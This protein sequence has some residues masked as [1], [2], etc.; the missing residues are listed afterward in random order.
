M[1]RKASAGLGGTTARPVNSRSKRRISGVESVTA[2]SLPSAP[3]RKKV[4]SSDTF[5]SGSPR[6]SREP[7]TMNRYGIRR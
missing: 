1:S 7:R 3:G 4:G 2:S 6:S 5:A